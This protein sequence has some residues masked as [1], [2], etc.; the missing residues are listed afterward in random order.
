MIKSFRHKGLESY[1]HTGSKSGIQPA[2]ASK[3]RVILSALD[4]AET[5][6]NLNAPRWKLH[7]LSGDLQNFWSITINGNW[8][9]VFRFD[10]QDIE[11]V[12]YL[13]YH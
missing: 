11:L 3:L 8:R 2:H 1:Y 7:S 9:I 10:G 6:D 4:V 12:D 5:P 13:D